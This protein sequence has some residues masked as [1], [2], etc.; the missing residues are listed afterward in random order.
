MQFQDDYQKTKKNLR[1]SSFI[2]ALF[3]NFVTN[4]RY[5]FK[6]YLEKSR[7]FIRKEPEAFDK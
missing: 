4:E 3:L 7:R 2:K 5:P 1:R 6:K